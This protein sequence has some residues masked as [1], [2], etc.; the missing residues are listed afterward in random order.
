MRMKTQTLLSVAF[1]VSV[2]ACLVA[3]SEPA[4]LQKPGADDA[5]I[6]KDEA[7]CRAEARERA[8]RVYPYTVGSP[9][10]GAAGV[11]TSQQRDDSNRAS[12]E[13]GFHDSCMRGKGYS[14]A[15]EPTR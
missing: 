14:R 3:C 8:S 6:A 1:A 12:A 5:T 4:P 10:F 15:A 2:A 11:M 7:D 9:S 13:V